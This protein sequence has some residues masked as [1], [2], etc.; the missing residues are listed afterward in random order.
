MDGTTGSIIQKGPVTLDDNGQFTSDATSPFSGKG[1]DADGSGAIGSISG[2]S[3]PLTNVNAIIHKIVN[4]DG[5]GNDVD[6]WIYTVG[7]LLKQLLAACGAFLEFGFFEELVTVAAAAYTDSTNQ[8]PANCLGLFVP[9]LVTVTIPTAT[10][11]HVGTAATSNLFSNGVSTAS[12]TT[13][14]GFDNPLYKFTAAT[15]VRLTMVGGTPANNNGRV[16]LY[17]AWI[18]PQVP[19]S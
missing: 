13:S 5:A 9:S 19:L 18:R 14:P 7:G 17:A 1:N 2:S 10:T 12:T 11:F 15:K 4:N 8:F 16:R 6:V 3:T